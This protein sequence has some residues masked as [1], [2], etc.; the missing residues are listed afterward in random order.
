MLP[1]DRVIA[2]PIATPVTTMSP[3]MTGAPYP[4][5][6]SPPPRSADQANSPVAP[7]KANMSPSMFDA[8]TVPSCTA[9]DTA[10]GASLNVDDHTCSPVQASVR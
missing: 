8:T 6:G 7:S 5:D 1:R 10:I 2:C 9:T 3:M 4:A